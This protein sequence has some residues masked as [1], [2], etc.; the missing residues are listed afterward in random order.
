MRPQLLQV[1][2]LAAAS[3][4]PAAKLLAVDGGSVTQAM[5]GGNHT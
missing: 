1:L 5:V 4:H 2:L 3:G